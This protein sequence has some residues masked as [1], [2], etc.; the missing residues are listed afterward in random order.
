MM[1]LNGKQ[2]VR[3]SAHWMSLLLLAAVPSMANAIRQDAEHD[4]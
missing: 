1:M 4:V 3:E 2:K